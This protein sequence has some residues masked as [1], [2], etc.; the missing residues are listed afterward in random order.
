MAGCCPD[1]GILSRN[2]RADV[3]SCAASEPAPAHLRCRK[4]PRERRPHDSGPSL[5]PTVT[6]ALDTYHDEC[7]VLRLGFWI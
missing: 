4:L 7:V 6:V 1:R 3:R 5:K 2:H